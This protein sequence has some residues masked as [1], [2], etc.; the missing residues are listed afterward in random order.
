M[1][2]QELVIGVNGVSRDTILNLVETHGNV[3]YC[4]TDDNGEEINVSLTHYSDP[5]TSYEVEFNSGTMGTM[6]VH[7]D[8]SEAIDYFFELVKQHPTVIE[9]D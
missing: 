8:I 2:A 6:M 4:Y 9:E 5:E 3:T 7:P 1:S